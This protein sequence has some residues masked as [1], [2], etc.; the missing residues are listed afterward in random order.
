MALA[1]AAEAY[2]GPSLPVSD[3]HHP[4]GPGVPTY[5]P[6][7]QQV[8]DAATQIRLAVQQAN[9]NEVRCAALCMW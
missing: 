9:T 5:V 2:Q 8:Q 4:Q 3:L 6:R 1:A 7:R